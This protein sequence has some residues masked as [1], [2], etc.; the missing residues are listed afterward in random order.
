MGA[1]RAD[2]RKKMSISGPIARRAARYSADVNLIR[3][4]LGQATATAVALFVDVCVSLARPRPLLQARP[5]PPPRPPPAQKHP[6]QNMPR[7]Q[8]LGK[9]TTGARKSAAD[10]GL[11]GQLNGLK[12]AAARFAD[13]CKEQQ[14]LLRQQ[15]VTPPRGS[16]RQDEIEQLRR[17]PLH[18]LGINRRLPPRPLDMRRLPVPQ[19][20]LELQQREAAQL[21]AQNAVA[22]AK[23]TRLSNGI[24][25][26]DAWFVVVWPFDPQPSPLLLQPIPLPVALLLP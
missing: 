24:R 14:P 1:P 23:Q 2:A 11:M 3:L 20:R 12:K 16:P 22:A 18:Q 7:W 6:Q 26:P 19:Q 10:A 15:Q 25:N 21:S 5:R 8:P 4:S 9:R 13:A 17:P